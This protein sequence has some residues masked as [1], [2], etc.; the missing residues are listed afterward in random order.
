MHHYV[1]NVEGAIARGDRYL[2]VVRGAGETHAAGMLS[3]V[4]GKVEDV[5]NL[6]NVLEETLRR[7]IREEVGLEVAPE[8]H[9]LESS[10][11]T[12]DDGD[13]VVDIVFLCFYQSG[14]PT[15]FDPHEVADLQWL[16]AAEV[17]VHPTAPPWTKRG[18]ARAEGRRLVR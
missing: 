10:A 15:I 9:Y 6:P 17:A 1:V 12:S 16:T 13:A 18:I 11:F 7:E 3:L 5:A 4:G 2:L 14:E 8:M